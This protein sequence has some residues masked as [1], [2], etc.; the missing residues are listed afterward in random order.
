MRLG[1][2]LDIVS[3]TLV[4]QTGQV[5]TQVRTTP[6]QLGFVVLGFAIA[7]PTEPKNATKPKA[8]LPV[9]RN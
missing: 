8:K 7:W 9:F 5:T 6:S 2:S 4:L 1:D 3:C